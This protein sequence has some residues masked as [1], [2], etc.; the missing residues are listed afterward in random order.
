VLKAGCLNDLGYWHRG[1]PDEALRYYREALALEQALADEDPAAAEHR[2]PLTESESKLGSIYWV[3]RDWAA[4]EQHYRR[5]DEL[6]AAL[7]REHPEEQVYRRLL[8]EIRVNLSVLYQNTARPEEMRRFHELAEETLESL[9]RDDPNDAASLLSLAVLRN[10]WSYNLAPGDEAE[11][12]LAKLGQSV[13]ALEEL[14]RR[15]P[16]YVPARRTLRE[17][18]GARAQ[19][20]ERLKRHA[21]AVADRQAVVELSDPGDQRE[22]GRFILAMAYARAG[23]HAEAVKEAEALTGPNPAVEPVEQFQHLAQVY[24]VAASKAG[25]DE[26]LPPAESER[27]AGRYADQAMALLAR[28]KAAADEA[29]WSQVRKVLESAKDFAPLRGRQDFRRLLGP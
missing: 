24:A 21:E 6:C 14:L 25:A 8:A 3:L 7:A 16:S 2:A 11:A 13:T 20:L 9:V 26:Q 1:S 12:G 27:L 4:A 29:R 15:E 23:R 22:I 19:L 28:A 5:A 10:N 17:V 18:H